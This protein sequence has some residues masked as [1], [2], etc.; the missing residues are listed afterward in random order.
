[1]NHIFLIAISAIAIFAITISV[2]FGTKQCCGMKIGEHWPY[3]TPGYAAPG[4]DEAMARMYQTDYLPDDLTEIGGS[5]A[6]IDGIESP[7]LSPKQDPFIDPKSY[8]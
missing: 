7:R 4:S 5:F 3:P 6:Q 8:L 2:Y 1:M